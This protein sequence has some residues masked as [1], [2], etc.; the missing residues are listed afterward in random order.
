MY[1]SPLE[2][3]NDTKRFHSSLANHPLD[4]HHGSPCALPALSTG[5]GALQGRSIQCTE[6]SA[7]G[8]T[9][10]VGEGRPQKPAFLISPPS[11]VNLGLRCQLHWVL[12]SCLDQLGIPNN[13]AETSSLPGWPWGLEELVDITSQLRD[14]GKSSLEQEEPHGRVRGNKKLPSRGRRCWQGR[15]RKDWTRGPGG[16]TRSG[17]WPLVGGALAGRDPR[18]AG[19]AGG[20]GA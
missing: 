7:V 5:P 3:R 10:S 18:R 15:G 16:C 2:P 8:D 17:V 20:G 4:Q 14:Q 1:R 13:Q 12:A 6:G 9:Y 11:D 19:P